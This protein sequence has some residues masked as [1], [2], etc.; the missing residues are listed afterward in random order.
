[1]ANKTK[2]K[3]QKKHRRGGKNTFWLVMSTRCMEPLLFARKPYKIPILD[4]EYEVRYKD[5][6]YW[7]SRY[8]EYYPSLNVMNRLQ[9]DHKTPIKVKL[10][11]CNENPDLYIQRWN[12]CLFVSNKLERSFIGGYMDR[13]LIRVSHNLMLSN[14]L[15]PEVTEESGIVGVKIVLA[16]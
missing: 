4:P 2:R 8:G 3:N 5:G 6:Y 11:V 12:D 10:A 16:D 13:E 14:K 1:M 9:F 7:F 15:F